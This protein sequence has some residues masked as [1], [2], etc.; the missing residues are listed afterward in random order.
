M[1]AALILLLACALFAVAPDATAY[2]QD[3][4][5]DVPGVVECHVTLQPPPQPPVTKCWWY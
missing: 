1:R 2:P 4:D 3:L 5:I